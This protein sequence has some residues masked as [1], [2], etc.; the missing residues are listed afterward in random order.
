[1]DR[2]SLLQLIQEQ[3]DP[4]HTGFI[5]VET[6]ASLVHSHELPLDPAKLDMLVALAQGNDE[7]QVCYQELVDLQQTFEQLQA[8]H[9][10]RAACPAPGRAAGRDRPGHL[11]TLRALRGL[12]DPALRDGQA[13]VLLPAPLLPAPR[14]HGS[15]HPH[16]DHR[17]PVLRCPAEQVGAAD[18]PPRVHEESSRLPPGAPGPRLA[19]PH[20]HVHARGAGAAGVQRPPAADDWGAPGDGAWHPAHQLP[21][22]GRRPGRL[23][24][25]LH[26]GHAGTSGWGLRGGLCPLLSSSRQRRHELGRDALPVQAAADGAGAGVHELRGGASRLAALLPAAASLGPAAQ[27]HGTPGRRHRGHQHGADHPAQLRG[28]PAGPVRLVGA[29][30]LLRHLPALRR[31]LEHL[32][33]RLAGGTDPA[34]PVAHALPSPP[35]LAPSLWVVFVSVPSLAEPGGDRGGR[36]VPPRV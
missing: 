10:Q 11:Q 33:L 15:R 8:C 16:A 20:L 12:R 2:S 7:G 3:L 27:L 36:G 31:L 17:V 35:A 28:E 9:R 25:R 21:L 26:H 13:L 34:P 5:G 32:R 1:M 30:P 24:H 23:P 6:F 19:L 22:P 14:L 4:E 29:A 18:L